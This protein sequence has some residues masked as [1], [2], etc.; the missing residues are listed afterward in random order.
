MNRKGC[1]Y[2][3]GAD[4]TSP[5]KIGVAENIGKRFDTLQAANHVA[6][7]VLW[8]S[9]EYDDPYAIEAALHELF[10]EYRVRGEWFAIPGAGAEMMTDAILRVSAGASS[11]RHGPKTTECM[12]IVECLRLLLARRQRLGLMSIQD[13]IGAIA[14]ETELGRSA[15]WSLIYRP[16]HDLTVGRYYAIA[17][18]VAREAGKVPFAEVPSAILLRLVLEQLKAMQPDVAEAALGEAQGRTG[19]GG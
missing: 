15:I 1:I 12:L 19:T 11:R 17:N 5:F 9:S 3:I 2:A 8:N 14:V 16:P 18:L 4:W 13:A 10:K 6:L 7:S